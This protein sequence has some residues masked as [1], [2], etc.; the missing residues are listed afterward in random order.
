[1]CRE[2]PRQ[3]S[4]KEFCTQIRSLGQEDPLEKEMATHYSILAWEIP[5]TEESGRLQSMG[6]QRVGH[7]LVSEEQDCAGNGNGC[8]PSEMEGKSACCSPRLLGSPSETTNVP[9]LPNLFI[10]NLFI[11][12]SL[13]TLKSRLRTIATK[14]G[15]K[16][17]GSVL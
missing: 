6:L 12:L 7:G 3:R 1:M 14:R 11:Y 8:E 10:P 2:I 9:K 17:M 5:W 13:G 4:G 15:G 16:A